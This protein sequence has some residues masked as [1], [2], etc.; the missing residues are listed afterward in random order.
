MDYQADGRTRTPPRRPRRWKLSLA[1]VCLPVL[2]LGAAAPSPVFARAEHVVAPGETL[3]WIA[4]HYGVSIHELVTRNRL[5]DEDHIEAGQRLII[6]GGGDAVAASYSPVPQGS[7]RTYVVRAGDSLSGIADH[8]GLSP[9]SLAARNGLGN[10]DHIIVG[11]VLTID[12]AAA[13]AVPAAPGANQKTHTVQPGETLSGIAD[14]YGLFA[15]A[16][17]AVN[18]IARPDHVVAGTRLIIPP[19]VAVTTAVARDDMG[20]IL[21]AAALEFGLDPA[22]LKAIAWQESGWNQAMVSHA[23]AVGVLQVIPSTG[24]WAAEDLLD[25]AHD[26]RTNARSNARLGAAVLRDILDAAEGDLE[27]AIAG[28]Y[29]GLRSISTIGWY[30]DTRQYVDNVLALRRQMR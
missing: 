1:A 22:L 16:V 18:G 8:Y 6:E 23:G 4:L 14:S 24:D 3:S 20:A 2:L 10:L 15:D 28:Y 7:G 27:L 5:V 17:A 13:A 9:A 19:R 26:W 30:E 12:G 11:Q 21:R 25:G 29:Q